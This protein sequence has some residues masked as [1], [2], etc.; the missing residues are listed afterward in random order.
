MPTVTR[1]AF[2]HGLRCL[3]CHREIRHYYAV[4]VDDDCDE[5]LCAACA[6][7]GVEPAPADPT[8]EQE[9]A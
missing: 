3:V 8:T 6:F 4:P 2:P 9:V 5:I 1:L 7:G